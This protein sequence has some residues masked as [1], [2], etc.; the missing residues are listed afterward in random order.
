MLL[1]KAE[2]S[3]IELL[4]ELKSNFKNEHVPCVYNNDLETIEINYDR[5]RY[6][7]AYDND[8]SVMANGNGNMWLANGNVKTIADKFSKIIKKQGDR[9]E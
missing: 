8:K 6:I 9:N 1:R 4:N 3:M 5:T 7:I 2:N